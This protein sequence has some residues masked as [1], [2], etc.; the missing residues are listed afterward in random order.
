MPTDLRYSVLER[1]N[2]TCQ[3]CGASPRKDPDVTLHVD[4]ITP[5][6]RGGLPLDKRNMITACAT[7]NLGKGDADTTT[8]AS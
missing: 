5:V 7:C 3:Y 4:H 2:F 8:D 6:S 1:D